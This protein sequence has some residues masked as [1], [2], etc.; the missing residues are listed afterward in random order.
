MKAQYISTPGRA[1]KIVA[2][3]W[4]AAVALSILPAYFVSGVPSINIFS[5]III[6]GDGQKPVIIFIVFRSRMLSNTNIVSC[7]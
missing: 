4:F 3:V 5:I 1:K 7:Q 2:A 6:I